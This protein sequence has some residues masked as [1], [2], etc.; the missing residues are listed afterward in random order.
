VGAA[1][2]AA[3][4]AATAVAVMV[5]VAA[6][7]V[8]GSGAGVTLLLGSQCSETTLRSRHVPISASLKE[9]MDT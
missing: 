6:V 2:T 1:A 9:S 8:L 4:A 3:A 7:D 5:V